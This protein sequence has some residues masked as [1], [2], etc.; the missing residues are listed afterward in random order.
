V[1]SAATL[2]GLV[3]SPLPGGALFWP[4]TAGTVREVALPLAGAYGLLAALCAAANAQGA[5]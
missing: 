5:R 1:A 3:H 2:F 4:W